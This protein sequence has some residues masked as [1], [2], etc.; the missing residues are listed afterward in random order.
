MAMQYRHGFLVF[1]SLAS[2]GGRGSIL[3]EPQLRKHA[4]IKDKTMENSD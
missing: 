1:G 4:T 2:L 3:S